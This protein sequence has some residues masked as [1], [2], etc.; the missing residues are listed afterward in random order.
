MVTK[1]IKGMLQDT[2]NNG[3]P[4]SELKKLRFLT[5]NYKE[6]F[7][8]TLSEGPPAKVKLLGADLLAKARHTR[9]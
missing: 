4:L 2:E 1:G 7:K 6:V 8:V 3:L 9:V 5:E